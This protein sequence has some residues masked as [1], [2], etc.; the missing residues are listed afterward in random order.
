MD[1]QAGKGDRPRPV[2][3]AKYDLNFLRIFGPWKSHRQTR[4]AAT[5]DERRPTRR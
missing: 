4:S 5:S 2:D 3:K 1:G